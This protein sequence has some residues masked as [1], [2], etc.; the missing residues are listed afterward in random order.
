MTNATTSTTRTEAIAMALARLDDPCYVVATDG[1][2]GVV[3]HDPGPSARV[4]TAV[5]PM[6]PERLGSA[7]FRAAHGT[8]F[9]YFAGAM[10]GGIATVDLVVRLAKAGCMGSF[11]SGGLAAHRVEEAL[12]RL[13]A[14][15]ADAPYAVNLLHSPNEPRLERDVVDLCLAHRVSCVEAS[16]YLELSP[17]IV[18]YRVAG[19]RRDAQG[20]VVAANRVIAKLSRPEVAA[21]FLSPAPEAMVAE[22]V[23]AGAVTT[24]QAELA[25]HVPMADD[26]TV[27]SDSGGHTDRRPL[28]ALF[29]VLV[30]QR[31]HLCRR[32][33]PTWRVRLGAA[34]GI[35]TPAA[36]AAAYAMGADYVV[37]GSVN[38]SCV[39]SGTSDHA[40]QML[41]AVGIADVDM[42]PSADMFELGAQV[43]V[44]KKGTM[45]PVRAKRLYQFY[46]AHG[47]LDELST[48][49]R[50]WLE[51]QVFR[52]SLDEIWVDVVDYFEQ[53]DPDQVKRAAADPKRRM[54]LVFRWYLG[55]SSRW[56]TGG[57]ADRGTD[58]QIWCGPAMGSFNDWVE[59]T[60]LAAPANRSVSEVAYHLLRGAALNARV[61][62]LAWTG[63][64]LS[65]ACTDYRPTPLTD[66]R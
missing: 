13:A 34:G 29:P 66:A 57:E 9:A 2:T 10:A 51:S 14:T 50:E 61:S 24:A 32:Y 38:Q 60:Y 19:L 64:R 59:G 30:R 58:Y 27:E 62:Q 43:Q 47:G 11:G 55:H 22:L 36:V 63:V 44:L 52:R 20:N 65:P 3:N 5:G 54:A 26:V 6:P 18:R 49:D 48:K 8:R 12:R 56:A 46:T 17:Q 33:P 1:G 23:A 7:R 25:R 28:G 15:L 4:I 16:A 45:F 42:A 40:R 53:R 31:D 37:T 21:R 41:A 39:E 35:G